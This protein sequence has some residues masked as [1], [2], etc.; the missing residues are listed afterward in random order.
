MALGIFAVLFVLMATPLFNVQ[1]VT[2][3]AG[4][5]FSEDQIKAMARV[6]TGKSFLRLNRADIAKRL[7]RD[8]WIRSASVSWR[9][10]H[11]AA[12]AVTERRPLARIYALGDSLLVADDGTILESGWRA[13]QAGILEVMDK[14]DETVSGRRGQRVEFQ[15]S[16]GVLSLLRLIIANASRIQVQPGKVELQDNGHV[17][18]TFDGNFPTLTFW[19]RAS[20]PKAF[21]ALLEAYD[22]DPTILAGGQ[23]VVGISDKTLVVTPASRIA[24]ANGKS[25]GKGAT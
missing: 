7:K 10:P 24:S 11:R 14:T 15:D 12:I 13:N 1:E 23:S 5:H 9:L 20:A 2:V 3:S 21:E 22:D 19:S 6:T 16:D 4:S 18:I 17:Q 25:G 8:P